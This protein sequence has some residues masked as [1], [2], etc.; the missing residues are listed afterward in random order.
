[1]RRTPLP[2][3]AVDIIVNF[4]LVGLYAQS[5]VQ[6]VFTSN[7]SDETVRV[8]VLCVALSTACI[9]GAWAWWRQ[10]K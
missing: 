1:M 4:D 10:R 6:M 7:E 2:P 5:A 9:A 8:V 3:Q